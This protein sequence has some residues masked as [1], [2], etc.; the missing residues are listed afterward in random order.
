MKRKPAMR[1]LP[2]LL[3]CALFA[4][5]GRAPYMLPVRDGKGI[6]K[7]AHVFW[8]AGGEGTVKSVGTV[9]EVAKGGD[10]A[11]P[12]LIRFDLK[13]EYRG[14]IREN[15][16]GAVLLDS[17]IA[18]SAFVLLLGGTGDG[19]EVLKPGVAIQEAK[20]ASSAADYATSFFGWLRN[21]RM[22]ELKVLCCVLFGLLILLK[23]VKS[24]LK[25]VVFL[26]L[27]GAIAYGVFSFHGDWTEQK[28]QFRQG[29]SSTFE[30]A[31]DWAARHADQLRGVLS[32]PADGGASPVR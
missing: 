23:I 20:P 21:A 14:V 30:Q 16:A 6:E 17:S 27:L 28:A 3:L 26:A 25:L 18:Q 9:T 15:V 11:K 19:K 4:G 32:E 12:V 22:G 8:D 10:A 13:D 5:C 7:G 24:I 29:V 31:T 2:A 1:L